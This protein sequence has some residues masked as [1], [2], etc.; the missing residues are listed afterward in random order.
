MGVNSIKAVP[1]ILKELRKRGTR[2]IKIAY[3]MDY[4]GN[5]HVEEACY[6]L[7]KMIYRLGFRYSRIMWDPAEQEDGNQKYK[8]LDDYL[9]GQ[10]NKED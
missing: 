3:D 8:G 10:Q 2:S 9:C 1:A 5:K 6:K 4:I 7:E